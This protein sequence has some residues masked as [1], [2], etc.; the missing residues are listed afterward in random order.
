MGDC[1]SWLVIL[2]NLG[3]RMNYKK[4]Q[5]PLKTKQ[6]YIACNTLIRNIDQG[7][8]I[9]HADENWKQKRIVK[10]TSD[11]FKEAIYRK[12]KEKQR[13]HVV[14][15]KWKNQSVRIGIKF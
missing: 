1:A 14:E 9:K 2:H 3:R 5:P 15:L 11:N 8:P 7:H 4:L 13:K 6:V 12:H 10:F